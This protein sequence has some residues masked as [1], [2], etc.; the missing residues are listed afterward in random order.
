MTIGS[1]YYAGHPSYP[2]TGDGPQ[3]GSRTA[4]RDAATAP[5]ARTMTIHVALAD[6][7]A[8]LRHSL[9]LALERQPDIEVVADAD[10]P[11][12]LLPAL[13]QERSGVLVL[14]LSSPVNGL[15]LIQDI[16]VKR[17]DVPILIL[18]RFNDDYFGA[19]ALTIGAS[20]YLGHDSSLED[21]APAIQRLADG[22]I[23]AR[24][25][26]AEELARA[27]IR[28]RRGGGELTDREYQIYL[29]LSDGLTV[30]EIARQLEISIK[31]VSTHK[32]RILQKLEFGSSLQLLPRGLDR[33]P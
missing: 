1:R 30:S 22:R 8:I 29:M 5:A 7:H 2:M 3:G 23:F 20:G 13:P 16:S 11:D 27:L 17:P 4:A 33:R 28:S 21:L 31:T 24:E 15:R 9:R 18:S 10:H 19:R 14:G 6:A 32:T 12:A 26:V 25:G